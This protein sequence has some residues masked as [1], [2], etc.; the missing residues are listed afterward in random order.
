MQIKISL[1]VVVCAMEKVH[2]CGHSSFGEREGVLF[3]LMPR[4]ATFEEVT[5]KLRPE[6]SKSVM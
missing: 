5:F 2:G 3:D 1:Q 4:K 6:R